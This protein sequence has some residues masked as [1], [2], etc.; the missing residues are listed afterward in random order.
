MFEIYCA[1][2][3]VV[4]KA[5]L[6]FG[7]GHVVKI[8]HTNSASTTSRIESGAGWPPGGAEYKKRSMPD[9]GGGS[10]LGFRRVYGLS[11]MTDQRQTEV[12]VRRWFRTRCGENRV[13]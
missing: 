8:G 9:A 2:N 10:E 6:E 13:D 1:F 12:R 11:N 7:Q 5:A 3:P 4:N